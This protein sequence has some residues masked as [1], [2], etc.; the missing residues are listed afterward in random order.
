MMELN[1]T[2]LCHEYEREKFKYVKPLMAGFIDPVKEYVF[3]RADEDGFIVNNLGDLH[4]MGGSSVST[5]L[6]GIAYT[7]RYVDRDEVITYLKNL[8]L[9]P[10]ENGMPD[11]SESTSVIPILKAADVIR[12]YDVR[13]QPTPPA[14]C[15]WDMSGSPGAM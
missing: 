6:L 13:I 11:F 8:F 3:Y 5:W 12:V 10:T 14:E 1:K 4:T 7:K 15:E 2:L 9:V